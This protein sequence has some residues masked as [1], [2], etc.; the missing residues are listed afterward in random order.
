[1]AKSQ[2]LVALSSPWQTCGAA[3]TMNRKFLPVFHWTIE[4]KKAERTE[5]S[6]DRTNKFALIEGSLHD[7]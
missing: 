6:D 7:P 5:K 3:I 2:A 1:M 4:P